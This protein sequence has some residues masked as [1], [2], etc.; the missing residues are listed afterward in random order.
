MQAFTGPKNG[1]AAKSKS[2]VPGE[3]GRFKNWF[4]GIEPVPR[5]LC[6]A[7]THPLGFNCSYLIERLGNAHPQVNE[8][9]KIAV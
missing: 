3:L 5:V 1:G 6:V 9:G 4:P 7:Y 2:F 8:R